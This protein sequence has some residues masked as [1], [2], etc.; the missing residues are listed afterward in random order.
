MLQSIVLWGELSALSTI[1]YH[2]SPTSETV[3]TAADERELY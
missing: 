1:Y 3:F 2:L